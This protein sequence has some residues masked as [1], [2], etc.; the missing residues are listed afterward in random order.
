MCSTTDI[1]STCANCGKKEEEDA[2]KNDLKACT[3]CKLVKYCNR[4]CQIAHRPR[5]KYDCK[6]RAAEL[7]DEILFKE[8]PP[9]RRV[10]CP[11]CMLP[12][13]IDT[14]QSVF[15]L[16][17]GKV[18]CAGCMYTM[19]YELEKNEEEEEEE[20]EEDD[21]D[22]GRIICAY[23]KT[24]ASTTSCSDE[25]RADKLKKL[26]ENG[27]AEA[28]N[29]LAS[30]YYNGKNVQQ[31]RIKARELYLKAGELGCAEAYYN[32][33]RSYY[34]EGTTASDKAKAKQYY[35]L[36]AIRGDV[37]ARYNL[38]CFEG[39]A[40]HDDRAYKHMMIAAK[41]GCK[42]ALHE[43]KRGYSDKYFVTKEEYESSLCAYNRR[44]D[45]MQS[46]MRDKALASSR[47]L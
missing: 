24:P 7:H 1:S 20:E 40:G 27:N 43:V 46:D 19:P 14:K 26:T 39:M 16:C 34:N 5:H 36:A 15:Q 9:S 44:V 12:L 13:P 28:C 6:K 42:D 4:D 37:Y 18:I 29:V 21:D 30:N 33:G 38:G 35:E 23:C 2:T 25:E 10:D 22:V 17:C 31:D 11:I 45:E 3:A 47:C 32:L 41:A 8:P